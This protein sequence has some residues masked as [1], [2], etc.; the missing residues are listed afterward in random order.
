MCEGLTT[1]ASKVQGETGKIGTGLKLNKPGKGRPEI[2]ERGQVNTGYNSRSGE[3]R[4]GRT[5]ERG[6]ESDITQETD[7]P[8]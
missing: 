5:A 8:K 4:Q 3:K 6:R 2:R 7:E 1:K